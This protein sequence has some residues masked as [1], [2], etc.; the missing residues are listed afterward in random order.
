M[1]IDEK[2]RQVC[3]AEALSTCITMHGTFTECVLVSAVQNGMP[4][5]RAAEEH[6]VPTTT[7]RDRINGRVVH[8]SKPVPKPYLSACEEKELSSF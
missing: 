2:L 4:I 3:L 8:G 7:L 1:L 5:K 6:G